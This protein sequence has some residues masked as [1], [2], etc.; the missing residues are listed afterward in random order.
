MFDQ[1]PKDH[2]HHGGLGIQREEQTSTQVF[3]TI[4]EML[5]SNR[6]QQG[7]YIRQIHRVGSLSQVLTRA[8]HLCFVVLCCVALCVPCLH[9]RAVSAAWGFTRRRILIS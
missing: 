4:L 2:A 1:G 8:V 6:M 7:S 9:R 3:C 5:I